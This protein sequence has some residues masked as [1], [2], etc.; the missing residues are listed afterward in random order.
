MTRHSSLLAGAAGA[1]V[2]STSAVLIKLSELPAT[3]VAALR[4]GYALP[5]LALLG[6]AVRYR[7][8][9]RGPR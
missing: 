6:L 8:G 2:I 7:R 1:A 3:T 9:P 5:V 4:T